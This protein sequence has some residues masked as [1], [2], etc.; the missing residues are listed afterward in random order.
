MS[1]ECRI[2]HLITHA[3]P[4]AC[5]QPFFMAGVP[6]RAPLGSPRP[7]L[8]LCVHARAPTQNNFTIP[9]SGNA[10]KRGVEIMAL[11]PTKRE[12]LQSKPFGRLNLRMI[13]EMTPFRSSVFSPWHFIGNDSG[14]PL[15]SGWWMIRSLPLPL[16]SQ[17]SKRE[18]YSRKARTSSRNLRGLDIGGSKIALRLSDYMG[19]GDRK[20]TSEII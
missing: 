4:T 3:L 15:I 12:Y 13:P 7:P 8:P 11:G 2:L 19:I 17:N 6:R 16:L 20:S 5:A 14:L 9:L 10:P 18:S 1:T